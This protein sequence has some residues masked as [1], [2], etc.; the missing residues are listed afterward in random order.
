MTNHLDDMMI[1]FGSKIAKFKHEQTINHLSSALFVLGHPL[2]YHILKDV[3]CI[4]QRM[5][6]H[7]KYAEIFAYKL[8][9]DNDVTDLVTLQFTTEFG[10]PETRVSC[11]V[12]DHVAN[13]IDLGD[14]EVISNES[15][16]DSKYTIGAQVQMPKRT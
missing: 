9:I 7:S 13:D 10:L 2:N 12:L 16:I 8:H 1:E 4:N 6:N 5:D 3:V 15:L 14:T 11:Q